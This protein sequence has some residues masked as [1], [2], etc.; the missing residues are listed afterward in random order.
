MEALY[1]F[2]MKDKDAELIWESH[3]LEQGGGFKPSNGAHLKYIE[4]K[5]PSQEE[6]IDLVY[7]FRSDEG[8]ERWKDVKRFVDE[9]SDPDWSNTMGYLLTGKGPGDYGDKL[10]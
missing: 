8:K 4:Q 10:D 9:M 6:I 3:V 2:K 5:V 1:H 7:Y